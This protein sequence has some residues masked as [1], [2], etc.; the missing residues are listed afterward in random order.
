MVVGAIAQGIYTGAK[1]VFRYRRQIYKTLVAQD[2]AIDRAFKVGGYGKQTRR[3]ARHGALGGSLIGS[4]IKNE[5]GSPMDGFQTS[6]QP[7]RDTPYQTRRGFSKRNR[8][9]SGKRQ[10][11]YFGKRCPSPGKRY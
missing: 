6:L 7:K 8:S 2:R 4:V 1:I 9:R 10:F 11:T 3:G 5:F